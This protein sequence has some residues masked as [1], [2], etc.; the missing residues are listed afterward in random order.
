MIIYDHISENKRKTALLLGAFLLLIIALGWIF[1]QAYQNPS[2]M[3]FA[4]GF[5]IIYSLISYYFSANITL[6]LSRARE[7]S[8]TDNPTLYNLVE[9]LA[10]TAGLPA[11]KIYVIEDTA[12]NAFATGRDPDRKS[13]V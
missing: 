4:V 5:S 13:V 3:Y 7:I 1:G 8:R 12:L 11:P 6:A 9:N 10:I 2:I